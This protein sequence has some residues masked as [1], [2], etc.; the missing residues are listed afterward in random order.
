MIARTGGGGLV[1]AMWAVL[2]PA[3]GC[4]DWGGQRVVLFDGK[5][6]NGWTAQDPDRNEWEVVGGV[7]LDPD[8]PKRF[9]V[10]PGTGV[11]INGWKGGISDLVG[12]YQHG[13]CRAH[14]EFAVSKG[15]NSGVYFQGRYEIQIYDS[16]GKDNLSYS[17]CGGIYARW[18]NRKGVDGQPPRVNACKPPG[19]WQTFDVIF[20]A[21]RFDAAG[22]KV[23]DAKYVKIWHNGQLIH[24]DATLPGPTRG[25][26][27]N[28]EVSTGPLRLQG[29][30][31]PVAYRNIKITPVK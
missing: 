12:S 23:A 5:D 21:P 26:L 10:T 19:E 9:K 13:D 18:V 25:P 6:L 7:E 27:S 16:F 15:S 14:I 8:N 24:E 29:D 22:A 20:K 17:D 1:L 11:L 31:G 30:H 28:K 4:S 2:A 3:A